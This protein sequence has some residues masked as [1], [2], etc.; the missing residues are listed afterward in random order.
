MTPSDTEDRLRR[1]RADGFI[2][3]WGTQGRRFLIVAG[4][5]F[6]PYTRR[7]TDAWLDGCEAMG[8]ATR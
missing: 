5:T 4:A 2:K 6:G 8:A 3:E 1:L 7:E